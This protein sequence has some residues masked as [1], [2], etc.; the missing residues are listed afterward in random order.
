MN[1]GHAKLWHKRINQFESIRVP[2]WKPTYERIPIIH[3]FVPIEPVVPPV[4]DYC[5]AVKALPV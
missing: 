4:P 5:D 2:A 1:C 3:V